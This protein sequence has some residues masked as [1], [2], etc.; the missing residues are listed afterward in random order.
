MNTKNPDEEAAHL[1]QQAEEKL[2]SKPFIPPTNKSESL[3]NKMIHE[4]EVHQVK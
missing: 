2:K 4:L 1:R 3:T